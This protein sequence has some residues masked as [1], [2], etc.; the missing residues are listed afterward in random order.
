MLTIV[1]GSEMSLKII[2]ANSRCK[3]YEKKVNP[4]ETLRFL[5]ISVFW[6]RNK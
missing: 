3:S 4:T 1:S 2:E 5:G 6:I